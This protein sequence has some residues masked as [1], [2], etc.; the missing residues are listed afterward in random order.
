[1][2]AL[3]VLGDSVPHGERTS[4]TTWPDRLD[5]VRAVEQHGG[6]G[7]S[8]T[9]LSERASSAMLSDPLVMPNSAHRRSAYT[10]LMRMLSTPSL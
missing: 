9:S 10:L 2:T 5:G 1:M 6:M 7:V 3:Y 8:L 4:D